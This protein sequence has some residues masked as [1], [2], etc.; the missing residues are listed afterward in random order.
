MLF[1][2]NKKRISSE[3]CTETSKFVMDT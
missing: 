3:N 1:D 2:F